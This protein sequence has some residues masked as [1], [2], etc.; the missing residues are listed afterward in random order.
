MMINVSDGAVL[1]QIVQ[2]SFEIASF[3]A[4]SSTFNISKIGLEPV[5]LRNPE[6]SPVDEFNELL[7]FVADHYIRTDCY[8]NLSHE[9]KCRECL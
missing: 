3:C 8:I 1:E 5:A 4:K 9:Y 7:L 6:T 2:F